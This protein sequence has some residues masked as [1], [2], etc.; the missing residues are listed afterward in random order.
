M[1]VLKPKTLAN[2][3]GS[4]IKTGN[5]DTILDKENGTS[6]GLEIRERVAHDILQM[7][8]YG[9]KASERGSVGI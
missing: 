2:K 6:K 8:L 5:R 4:G 3:F 9:W 1:T 7:N